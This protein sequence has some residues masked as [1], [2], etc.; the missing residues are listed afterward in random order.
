MS[1][2]VRVAVQPSSAC[3]REGSAYDAAMSPGRR[4]TTSYGRSRPTAR[5]KAA[6]I[7]RTLVPWPVPRFQVL[8]GSSVAASFVSAATWP[9]A[10]SSTWM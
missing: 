9:A 7:S 4:P 1:S 2:I 8:T 3:A 5:L 6:S 10:R